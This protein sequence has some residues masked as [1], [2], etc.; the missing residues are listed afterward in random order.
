M[1]RVSS[2]RPGPGRRP[3]GLVAGALE[4][5]LAGFDARQHGVERIG[6]AADLVIVAALGPQG[7]ALFP[8]DLAR[9][10]FEVVDRQGDQALDLPG[11]DQPQ[12]DAEYQ[13][14]QAGGEGAG[15]ERHRQLAA[16]HQQQVRGRVGV[17]RQADQL[18]AA[19]LHQAPAVDVAITLGQGEGVAVLE[20][21]EHLP[22]ATVDGRRAQRGVAVELLEQ[23]AGGLR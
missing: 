4:L 2:A 21:G 16:G 3:A 18:G 11:D 20:L 10:F 9:Q 17:A 6:Q 14:R 7:V 8:G 15:V 13:D 12:Q 5:L 1:W 23:G 19:K 22:I